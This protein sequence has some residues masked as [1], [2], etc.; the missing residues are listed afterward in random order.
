MNA[1]TTNI[2]T[3]IPVIGIVLALLIGEKTNEE[4]KFHMNQ[5]L[6]I[7]IL[8]VA[9]SI[10]GIVMKFIPIVGFIVG[11]ILWLADL[12]LFVLAIIALIFAAQDKRLEIPVIGNIKLIQ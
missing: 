2:V 10:C 11:I 9:I 6:I 5:S 4:T 1:K 12:L 7:S 3:Y 8:M